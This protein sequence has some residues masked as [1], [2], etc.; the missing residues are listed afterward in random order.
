MDGADNSMTVDEPALDAPDRSSVV[1]DAAPTAEKKDKDKDKDAVTLEDLIL[2]KSIITRLAKGVL[3]PNTQIQANAITALSKSAVVFV[4]HLAAAANELTLDNNRKTITPE[5][6]FKAVEDIEYG[7]MRP[8][9]EAEFNKFASVQSTK[10]S[11]YRRRVAQAKKAATG[12]GV[13]QSELGADES[14]RSVLGTSVADAQDS[15]QPKAKKARTDDGDTQQEP[16]QMELDG[17]EHS[18]AETVPDDAEDDGQDQDQED[19]ADED[20]DEDEEEEEADEEEDVPETNGQE[21]EHI[22]EREAPD[23]QDEALD[24]DDSE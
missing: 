6:V 13:S 11:T 21:H 8:K 22:E 19:Q 9:L 4:N 14:E 17:H 5:D 18:D 24:G 15:P 12:G 7:F 23:S 2:P 3:P 20:E 1:Q 16:S 10:R